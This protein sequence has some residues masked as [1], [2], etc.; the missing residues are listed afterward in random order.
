MIDHE[1]RRRRSIPARPDFFFPRLPQRRQTELL[2]SVLG[3]LEGI[4]RSSHFSLRRQGLTAWRTIPRTDGARI[5]QLSYRGQDLR[6][7][8]A[9]P[10]TNLSALPAGFFTPNPTSSWPDSSHVRLLARF[11]E[12]FA[13]AV[14][15]LQPG[16]WSAPIASSYGMHLVW[17]MEKLPERVPPKC[18]ARPSHS[19]WRVALGWD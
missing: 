2:T 14:F 9:A 1:F 5:S 13:N 16:G 8:A 4:V 15:A 17:V 18:S 7:I 6:S 10:S 12:S 3:S 19:F 11:G